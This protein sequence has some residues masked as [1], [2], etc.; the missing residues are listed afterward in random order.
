[1]QLVFC[2]EFGN[3]G[4]HLLGSKQPVFVYAFVLIDPANLS[5]LE[6]EVRSIYA[7]EHLTLLELKSSTLHRS[8]RGRSRY[9]QIGRVALNCNAA[10]CL[11]VVEK[12]YQICSMIVETYLDALLNPHVPTELLDPHFRQR[13][14]DACYDLLTDAQLAR[15]LNVVRSDE[16][17]QIA[18]M[19][20]E[21]SSALEWHPD[22]FVSFTARQM[23]TAPDRV[24]RYSQ[25][26]PTL[27]KN[28]N[29]PAS[30]YAGFYAGLEFVDA[31]LE[32]AG[33]TGE[34]VRDTDLQFGEALDAAFTA[35][36][37]SGDTFY[38]RRSALT[39]L[40]KCRSAGSAAEF[41]VQLAD[42]A[43][44]VF[45]RLASQTVRSK[46]PSRQSAEIAECWRPLLMPFG[47]HYLMISDSVSPNLVRAIFGK[48]ATLGERAR[49]REA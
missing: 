22:E 24:F 30:Q 46:S 17:E 32:S 36:Q 10:V 39:Q 9:G 12:R 41:G 16:P 1:M 25:P 38:R 3:T 45:G 4:A 13:F 29:L 11:S 15:F 27:P 37:E 28:S 21:L 6:A 7:L 2:D 31:F 23:D 35:A 48:S 40:K 26:R 43:A 18:A 44:G 14:A 5:Q 20:A 19:G 33:E 49:T 34:L 8:D 42:L 47:Q